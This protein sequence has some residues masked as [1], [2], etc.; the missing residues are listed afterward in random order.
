VAVSFSAPLAPPSGIS[1]VDDVVSGHDVGTEAAAVAAAPCTCRRRVPAAMLDKF[2]ANETGS[3]IL[4]ACDRLR[5]GARTI[6]GS[7]Y[8]SSK[9][10]ARSR[11]VSDDAGDAA[12]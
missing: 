6:D 12:E 4:V 1:A 10:D 7:G 2:P 11:V 5:R 8:C 3:V 9:L